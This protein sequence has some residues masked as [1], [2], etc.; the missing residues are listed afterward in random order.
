MAVAVVGSQVAVG[1]GVGN[2][3]V[4]EDS[5]VSLAVSGPLVVTTSTESGDVA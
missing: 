5:T 1:A 2:A 3:C 4:S